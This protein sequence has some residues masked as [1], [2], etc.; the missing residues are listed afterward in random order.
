MGYETKSIAKITQPAEISLA[1]NP[2]F[3]EF[4]SLQL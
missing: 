3:V 2:N 1:G 4:E